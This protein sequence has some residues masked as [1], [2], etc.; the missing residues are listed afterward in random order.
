MKRSNA[1]YRK[2]NNINYM[3][4]VE[5]KAHAKLIREYSSNKDYESVN[6]LYDN[7]FDIIKLRYKRREI[8]YD[9]YRFL[10][11]HILEIE[12]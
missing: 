10:K 2:R 11:K 12:L 5:V 1:E 8:S 3:L 9:V 7:I 6:L 4:L